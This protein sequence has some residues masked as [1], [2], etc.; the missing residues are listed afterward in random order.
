MAESIK[1]TCPEC[2]AKYRLPVEAAGRQA[3]CK[4]CGSKF[5]VPGSQ[6]LEDS[7]LNWLDDDSSTKVEEN[8]DKPKVIQIPRSEGDSVAR[9]GL[10]MKEAPK[11]HSPAKR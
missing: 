5:Q 2:N 10:R 8:V 11:G 4:V 6:S 7:V 1:C 3:R 9:T